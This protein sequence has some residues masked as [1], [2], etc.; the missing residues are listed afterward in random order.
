[1]NKREW[2]PEEFEEFKQKQIELETHVINDKHSNMSVTH[3]NF[4][5]ERQRRLTYPFKNKHVWI[6]K[7]TG[8]GA[9]EFLIR[10][11]VWLA[12]R[13]NQLSGTNMCI[14]IG[15]RV[16]TSI[17]IINRIKKLFEPHGIF[18]DSKQTVVNIN[19]VNITAYP[20]D[21]LD[22]MRSLTDV[23]FILSDESDF[24]SKSEQQNVRDVIERY[25]GKTDPY[26]CLVSTPNAPGG[27]FEQ[28]EK[29]SFDTCIYKKLVLLYYEGL[30]TIYSNEEI[31]NVKHS[32]SFPREYM[33]QY[34]GLE[35]N[36]FTPQSIEQITRSDY[37]PDQI[38]P[39]CIVSV[40]LDPAF[41]SSRFGV[42]V[43]R[44]AN[45]RIEVLEADEYER[46]DIQ[47]MIDIVW[48]LKQ[49]YGSLSAIYTDASMS[50]VWQPLK[51]LFNEMTNEKYVFD[52]I[53][54]CET[55]NIPI[56]RTMRV[57]PITFSNHHAKLLQHLKMLVD[58][59]YLAVHPKFT[60][61]LTALR[62]AY[63][64]ELKYDKSGSTSQHTDVFD[65][66]RLAVQVYNKEE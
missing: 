53:R 41:G 34:I 18:F 59:G 52:R 50:V 11:M 20:S 51:K 38:I 49:K 17:G 55:H 31:E 24:Y 54:Y 29:E 2:T 5:A 10:I 23:S 21:H 62:T 3:Q 37:N 4:L 63:A 25:I 60:K 16:E 32:L 48:Q 8:I 45:N 36:V 65:A 33:G 46:A 12:T 56:S 1:L 9:T 19:G 27:L 35:G 15:P 6:K 66:L 39:G 57:I 40:G 44:F 61:L 28:I 58:G 26:I 22:S 47:D 13:D 14:V 42:V 64:T 7:S 30:G 43:T